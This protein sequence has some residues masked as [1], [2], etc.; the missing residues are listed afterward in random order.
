MSPG[1]MS[2]GLG[3][4]PAVQTYLDISQGNRVFDSL[5]DGDLPGQMRGGICGPRYS[6]A[7]VERAETAPADIEPGLLAATLARAGK[8]CRVE[9]LAP[10]QLTEAVRRIQGNDLLIAIERAPPQENRALAVGVAGRGFDGNLTSDSTRLDGYVLSTDVAPTVLRRLGVAVP[11]AMSGQPIRTEGRVNADAAETLGDRIAVV[12]PRRGPVIGISLLVWLGLLGL[13]AAIGRGRAARPA[14]RIVGLSVVYLP[15]VLLL[16]AAFEPPQDVE[17]LA[18]LLGAP[19]LAGITLFLL[20]GYPALATASALV[21]V[22]YAVDIVAGSSLTAL[23]LLGPNP[24]LG[25]RFYGIGNELEAMLAVLVIAGTGAAIS[26]FAPGLSARRCAISFLAVGLVAA[27]VFAAGRFGA[28]VGAAIV[29]PVGAGAA[30]VTV[31]KGGRRSLFLVAAIPLAVIALIALA[32]L[33]SGANAHLTRSVLDAGGLEDLADV[34]QRRLQLSARSF[35]RPVVL[36]FLPLVAALAAFALVH[37]ATVEAWLSG[38][39]AMRAGLLGALAATVI[40]TLAN[41]SGALLLEIGAAYL[42]V[43]LAFAWSEKRVPRRAEPTR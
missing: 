14:T 4:V 21:V 3:S 19:A 35:T 2:A 5:Y 11:S 30:A 22:A 40:G 6:S 26:G 23:S 17:R 8:R 7:V 15:L 13:A 32:D 16:G 12:S 1:L 34:A 33:V 25:V 9:S 39:L 43:F 41:D 24:A 42:L 28:D 36:L 31:A 29:F 38:C 18:V 20:G 37:R 27:A 10:R